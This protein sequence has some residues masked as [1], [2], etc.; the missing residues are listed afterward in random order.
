MIEAAPALRPVAVF[1]ELQRRNTS[2]L[3]TAC[4]G[5]WSVASGP[6]GRFMGQAATLK[7]P[8]NPRTWPAWPLRFYQRQ[9]T[10]RDDRRRSVQA[11][12][13]PLPAGLVWFRARPC[14]ARR[15]KLCRARRGTAERAVGAGWG[16]LRASQRQPAGGL[17]QSRSQCAQRSDGSLRKRFAP[18]TG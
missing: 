6:G 17:P 3:A 16:A 11:Q 2:S 5:R 15:R 1:E 7:P 14:R 8:A 10:L 12:L 9:R 4:A 13:L 18:I